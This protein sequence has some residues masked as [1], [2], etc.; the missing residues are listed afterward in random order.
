MARK[1]ADKVR[2][3]ASSASAVAAFVQASTKLA[4]G[5]GSR[6]AARGGIFAGAAVTPATVVGS[7]LSTGVSGA[8][9]NVR[10]S[11]SVRRA[12]RCQLGVAGVRGMSDAA[13]LGVGRA[14][15]GAGVGVGFGVG[16]SVGVGVAVGVGVG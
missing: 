7:P 2:A 5:A 16:V 4:G 1:F 9:H 12:F 8:I 3:A 13:G 10:L 14:A 15:G 6:P 11:R